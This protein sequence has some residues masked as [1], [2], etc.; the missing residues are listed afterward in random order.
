NLVNIIA[1]VVAVIAAVAIAIVSLGSA[2]WASAGLIAAAIPL[3]AGAITMTAKYVIK[4]DRYGE[5]EFLTDLGNTLA[6]AVLNVVTMGN[7]KWLKLKGLGAT[8][9]DWVKLGGGSVMRVFMG[10]V[11]KAIPGEMKNILF[12]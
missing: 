4:G 1:T 2:T 8:I 12:N 10:E 7:A 11:A 3:T 6:D 5:E 9:D